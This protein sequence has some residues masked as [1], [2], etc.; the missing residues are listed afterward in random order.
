MT[1]LLRTTL[2]LSLATSLVACA[3]GTEERDY[4]DS[5]PRANVDELLA[6]APKADEIPRIPRKADEFLPT[7]HTDLLDLQSPVRSQGRR[8]VCSIFSTVG[9]MEHLYLAEGTHQSPDFS[10]QYLQWSAKFEVNS[11]PSTSGS[12]ATYNLQAINRFGIVDEATYPYQDDQWGTTDDADCDG[13][14]SQPTRCYTNGHPSD[15]VKAAQKY[16]LPS[17][18][19][20]H[21][22][23]IKSHMMQ[24]G[25][26]AIVGLTFFYQSWNHRKSQL[27]RNL[28][29]WDQG[30]VTYP[31]EDDKEISLEKRAGH[32]ILLVGW[33]DNQ[34]MPT[35]D[36]D[37]NP[38]VDG[39]GDVVME[40]GCYIFKNSWG[41]S[42]F[43]I[44]SKWGAGY[45]CI[46]YK[47]VNEYG[48]LRSAGLPDIEV[49]EEICGDDIDNDGNSLTDCEDLACSDEPECQ[50]VN[51][52]SFEGEGGLSIP[53][54]DPVGV[55][56]SINVSDVAT[57]RGLR[58]EVDISHTYRS[59]LR[60]SLHRGSE[61]IVLH[62]RT[63]GGAD[64]LSLEVSL[65]DWNGSDL[66]GE[67]RLVIV[68]SARIDVG[69]LN[70][71]R[72]TAVID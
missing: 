55:G 48:R 26:G 53:D 46:S 2:F 62:D 22:G 23:D 49:P 34:E 66:E 43:G 7:S 27:Q 9:L 52:L 39:N 65:D 19:W 72:L 35:L 29:S 28:D 5:P 45:G 16:F 60:V 20:L 61:A 3:A 11:F 57:I 17:S 36:G 59:D 70:S 51:E 41:T 25:T 58:V 31:S 42:G 37:G 67:Y 38:V 8:G 12:N 15:E 4:S 18:R 40:T 64:N 33:D 32:S 71:W 10:E 24:S 30:F 13:E 69:T 50:T 44:D 68:D 6:G 21:H 1:N 54:N 14:D 47:Y 56:S 63:G